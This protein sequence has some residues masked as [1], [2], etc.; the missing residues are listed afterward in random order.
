MN[1]KK[2]L[3]L[4]ALTVAFAVSSCS[5]LH[6]G[7]CTTNC[8]GNATLSITMSDTPPTNTNVVSFS[9]PIIGITLTP[10]SGSQ[11]SVFSSNPSTDFELT[12]LQS[13]TNLVVSKV[14][15]AEGTYTAIN[16]TVAAPSGT[17]INSSGSTIGQCVAGAVCGITGS[18]ATITYTYPTGSPLVLNSNANQ[19]LNLDFNYNNAV[20]LQ[21]SNLVIDV[22]QTGVMSASSTVATNVPSGN[23]ANLDDFTGQVSAISSSSI[24]LKSTVRGTLTAVISSATPVYDPQN[25]CTGGGSLSCIA[26]GS[27]VSAQGLL[28][29]NGVA[30]ATSLDVIDK[31]TSPV[32]EVEGIIY[33]SSCGGTGSYGLI[34]SD[35]AITTSSSPLTSANFGSGVCLTLSTSA[36]F[37]VDLGILTG[38]PGVPINNAG[39]SSTGDIFN[40]Q[41]VRVKVTNAT[42]GTSGINATATELILRPTRFTAKVGTISGNAFT[43]TSLPTY[44][45]LD[46]ASNFTPQVLTY[47]NATILEGVTSLNNLTFGQTVGISALFLNPT[48]AQYPF[49]AVKVRAF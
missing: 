2:T 48:V 24:T 47:P 37:A 21:S 27:V 35:S 7:G 29:S 32:D 19:W 33:A 10:S 15:V 22:T 17:F 44:L 14:T 40:G 42:S 18:A 34:L 23:F 9:L 26:V 43:I 12:R 5:G 49:H 8:G 39:F 1:S 4:I 20:L 28:S 31:S 13:D 11:V 6:S 36:T 46:F 3:L 38:Q 25:L 41:T 45:A 30:T 16:V